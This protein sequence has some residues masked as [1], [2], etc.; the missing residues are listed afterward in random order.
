MGYGCPPFVADRVRDCIYASGR[1]D[2][3]I[4]RGIDLRNFVSAAGMI[5]FDV[6]TGLPGKVVDPIIHL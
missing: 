5:G 4:Q 3:F 2:C 6:Y 1:Y